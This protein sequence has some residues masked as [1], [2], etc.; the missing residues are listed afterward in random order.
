[1]MEKEIRQAN[2]EDLEEIIDLVHKTT[3]Y[4][5]SKDY[6]KEAIDYFIEYHSP[7]NIGHDIESGFALVLV[8]DDLVVSTGTLL[9]TN[10]RR[11]FTLPQYQGQGFG[12][13]VM[14]SLENEAKN[15]NLN[16]LDLHSSLPGKTFYDNRKYNTLHFCKIPVENNLTLDYYRMAKMV[17]KATEE[18]FA[19]LNNREFRVIINEGPGAEVNEETVF[20]FYQNG[21]LVMGKYAGGRIREGE[22][23][24]CIDGNKFSFQYEQLNVEGERNTGIA[25]DV[26]EVDYDGRIRI[27]DTWQWKTK[28]GTGHCI[29]KEGR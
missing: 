16:F 9:G 3:L 18:P 27:I 19:N 5:Y 21:G 29:L 26:I 10:I 14:E 24:G 11:V 15:R 4:S 20:T 2:A 28:E 8:Q 17:Q 7:E 25:N 13:K 1:M 12:N 23:I 22:I 6:S